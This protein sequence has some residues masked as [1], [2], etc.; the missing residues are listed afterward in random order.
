MSALLLETFHLADSAETAASA[1][2]RAPDDGTVRI[3]PDRIDAFHGQMLSGE[4]ALIEI[5]V[6][7]CP[8]AAHLRGHLTE[9]IGVFV[10][11]GVH[12]VAAL[13]PAGGLLGFLLVQVFRR[14]EDGAVES[15]GETAVAA[16]QHHGDDDELAD[17]FELPGETCIR[18]WVS[19]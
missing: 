3:S 18:A 13:M 11:V 9:S 14:E 2:P 10:A 19:E 17:D 15:V 8:V 16:T 5:A 12:A 7:P 1:R 4:S 6:F